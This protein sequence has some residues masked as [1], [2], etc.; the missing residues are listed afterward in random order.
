MLT[1]KFQ[2][3]WLKFTFLG[4]ADSAIRLGVKSLFADLGLS[5]GDSIVGLLFLSCLSF[6]L[7]IS[8]FDQT[9]SLHER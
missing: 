6:F 2:I 4:E 8:P 7:I 1:R 9:L 5:T 3:D